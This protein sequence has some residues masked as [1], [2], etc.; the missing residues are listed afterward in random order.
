MISRS[1]TLTLTLTV[2]LSLTLTLS[3][4]LTLTLSLTPTLTLTLTLNFHFHLITHE[5]LGLHTP[6]KSTTCV[7]TQSKSIQ[8]H[9]SI[10]ASTFEADQPEAN[11]AERLV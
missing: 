2:T 7:L 4:T 11:P 1:L 10:E 3:V 6:L 5:I 9:S 8:L